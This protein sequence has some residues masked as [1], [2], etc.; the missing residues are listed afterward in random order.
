MNLFIWIGLF[1]YSVI[2]YVYFGYPILLS[3]QRF[4]FLRK[5]SKRTVRYKT[6]YQIKKMTP[7]VTLVMTMYNA[8]GLVWQ[9]IKNLTKL[10]YGGNIN[11]LFVLDGCSDNTEIEIK[12]AAT[13]FAL[14]NYSIVA[15]KDRIGKEQAIRNALPVIADDVLVFSDADAIIQKDAITKLVNKLRENGVGVACGKEIQKYKQKE[16]AGE[17]QGL[18]YKYE[19]YIKNCQEKVQR[20]I[21]YV[22]GGI[23]A[24][25]RKH[26][27]ETIPPGATQD[28][29]IAFQTVRNGERVAYAEDAI[30]LET[31][32]VTNQNDF[33]RRKRT[34]SRSFYAIL[35][36][37]DILNFFKYGMFSVDVLSSRALRWITPYIAI[38]A[39]NFSLVGFNGSAISH[40]LVMGPIVFSLIAS[41][42]YFFER[43][44]KRAKLPYI[45]YYFTYIHIAAAISVFNVLRGHRTI[46]WK[47]TVISG[48]DSV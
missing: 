48:Q 47:P 1:F 27:P 37:R 30:S 2:L 26:Y 25:K 42:G 4:F 11:F 23:F 45:F 8:E 38:I 5:N 24:M 46:T 19:N 22:Q 43:I 10:I 16:G 28:G 21:C 32:D 39:F 14:K 20:S 40:V 29:V 3:F 33:E 34:I 12:K 41:L 35:Y 17:G 7:N 44:G 18:F 6:R 31:Y 36:C 13:N 15:Q 9:K